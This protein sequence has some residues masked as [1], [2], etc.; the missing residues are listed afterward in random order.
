MLSSAAQA[1]GS[2]LAVVDAVMG[3]AQADSQTKGFAV[4][5]PPGHHATKAAP[6][7]FCLFNNVAIAARYAQQKYGLRKVSLQT[8]A[9]QVLVSRALACRPSRICFSRTVA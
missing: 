8:G 5:R 6:M 4:I 9:P 3:G 2:A 1:A 7:G